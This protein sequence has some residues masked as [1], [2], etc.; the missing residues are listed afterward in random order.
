MEL[1]GFSEKR[2]NVFT[3]HAQNRYS[4]RNKD[5]NIRSV[6]LERPNKIKPSSHD[7]SIDLKRITYDSEFR[8]GLDEKESIIK[9]I[10]PVHPIGTPITMRKM[11]CDDV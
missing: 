9:N 10:Q 4:S 7:V 2:K 8:K 1:S 3:T 5:H 6:Q 11:S